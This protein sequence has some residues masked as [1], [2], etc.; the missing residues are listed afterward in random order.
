MIKIMLQCKNYLG[1]VIDEK[2]V[3]RF[4]NENWAKAFG[5]NKVIET[6][7]GEHANGEFQ[8]VVKDKLK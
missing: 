3:A 8:L 4:D 2:E 6:F 5:V 1:E 7:N